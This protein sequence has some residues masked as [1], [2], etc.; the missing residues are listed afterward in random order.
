MQPLM[1]DWASEHL[2]RAHELSGFFEEGYQQVEDRTLITHIPHGSNTDI[3]TAVSRYT[4]LNDAETLPGVDKQDSNA[5]T[6][7]QRQCRVQVIRLAVLKPKDWTV[8]TAFRIDNDE[9]VTKTLL[10]CLWYLQQTTL[11]KI[12]KDWIKGICP[13]KQA[14]YPYRNK[15]GEECGKVVAI[16]PWWPSEDCCIFREPDHVDRGREY[17]SEAMMVGQKLLTPMQSD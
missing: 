2:R 1:Q 9:A 12:A 16:P 3:D 4:N 11:K 17:L 7:L 5:Q 15:K 14:K 6:S 8:E 13:R 10:T